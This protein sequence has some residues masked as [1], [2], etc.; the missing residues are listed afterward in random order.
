[1]ESLILIGCD[2]WGDVAMV[3]NINSEVSSYTI[4]SRY[5]K[6]IGTRENCLLFLQNLVISGL[7]KQYNT[8]GIWNLGHP[9]ITLL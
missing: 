1:M 8:E 7:Q 9:Q 5:N 4:D 3:G 2:S 6:L